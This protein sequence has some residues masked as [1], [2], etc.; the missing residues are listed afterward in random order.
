VN[1]PP[2]QTDS[3]PPL[4]PKKQQPRLYARQSFLREGLETVLLVVAIYTLVNL[5]TSRYV[6]EGQSMLPTFQGEE[7]LIV[8]RFEY[9]IW[10]PERGDI[11]IFHNPEDPSKDFIKRVIGLPGDYIRMEN[12][13]VF[14][15]NA[16]IAEP[17]VL[18]LCRSSNCR[19]REWYVGEDQYFVLGD[20]RNSSQD[21]TRFGPVDRQY[22]VGRAWIKYWPPSEWDI[23][24]H[25]TYGPAPDV[26]P[27]PSPTPSP[28]P[29]PAMT[30]VPMG[31]LGG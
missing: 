29:A 25:E 20:N 15:N 26:T 27:M 1:I 19:Y 17:Y 24:E 22:L 11:V 2:E 28:T 9:L 4:P 3:A 30:E 31:G 23:I 14:V 13:Q 12:G 21:S 16:P 8:N 6:V 7:Y 18:D 5:C 10:E